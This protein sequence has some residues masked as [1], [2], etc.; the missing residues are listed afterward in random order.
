MRILLLAL[1]LTPF[2][3]LGRPAPLSAQDPHPC[4][5][6]ESIGGATLCVNED[7]DT[8]RKQTCTQY[9][10]PIHCEF[11]LENCPTFVYDEL[12]ADASVTVGGTF[13][14][15]GWPGVTEQDLEINPCTGLVLTIADYPDAPPL[16]MTL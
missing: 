15:V 3:I 12:P 7:G 2:T 4:W 10:E 1:L 8:G 13:L 6:C 9:W 14:G 11:S 16:T 5:G